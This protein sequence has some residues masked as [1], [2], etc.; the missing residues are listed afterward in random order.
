MVT[1]RHQRRQIEGGGGGTAGGS[2]MET[3]REMKPKGGGYKIKNE[4]KGNR[5]RKKGSVI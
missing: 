3:G 1:R 5:T 4:T 2:K